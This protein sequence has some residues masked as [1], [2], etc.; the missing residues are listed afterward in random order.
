MTATQKWIL[1]AAVVAVLFVILIFYSSEIYVWLMGK[2]TT[3][4]IWLVIFAAGW[5]L[6]R[7]GGRTRTAE[8]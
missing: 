7:F 2:L 8:E 1:G 6:G 5:L 4:I 3:L